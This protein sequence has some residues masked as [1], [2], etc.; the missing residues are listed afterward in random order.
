MALID[1]II[2]NLLPQNLTN[3]GGQSTLGTLGDD[4]GNRNLTNLLQQRPPSGLA[5]NLGVLGQSVGTLKDVKSLLPSAPSATTK[6]PGAVAPGSGGGGSQGMS[7][8]GGALTGFAGLKGAQDIGGSLFSGRRGRQADLH[9][10]RLRA[11]QALDKAQSSVY[12]NVFKEQGNR[13][14][15]DIAGKF[16]GTTEKRLRNVGFDNN[17]ALHD[18]LFKG[19]YTFRPKP[20]FATAPGELLEGRGTQGAAR[21]ITLEDFMKSASPEQADAIIRFTTSPSYATARSELNSLDNFVNT[22]NAGDDIGKPPLVTSILSL[23]DEDALRRY[24]NG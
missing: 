1:R 11:R 10:H 21:T 20:I 6:T 16:F 13:V 23:S 3:L 5:E 15:G 17:Q 9:R 12:R 7:L 14:A 2:S 24:S 19:S 8:L 22:L 4:V 18:L